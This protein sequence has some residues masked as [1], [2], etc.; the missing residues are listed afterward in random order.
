MLNNRPIFR[1]HK[2]PVARHKGR[3]PVILDFSEESTSPHFIEEMVAQTT[4]TIDGV[5]L[6]PQGLADLHVLDNKEIWVRAGR[7]PACF[8]THP[9]SKPAVP[10]PILDPDFL[11]RCDVSVMIGDLVLG[12]SASDE[13]DTIQNLAWLCSLSQEIGLPLAID[14][15]VFNP[16]EDQGSYLEIVELGLNLAIELGGNLVIIPA[17]A[18]LAADNHFEQIAALPVLVKQPTRH[19]TLENWPPQAWVSCLEKLDGV[20]FTGL[21]DRDQNNQ[22]PHIL[23]VWANSMQFQPVGG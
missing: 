1:E 20:I 6:S 13:A 19:L 21:Q 23:D 2:L 17:G 18:Y 11:S 12:G 4:A 9:L 3:L 5:I 15:H 8:P 14:L 7:A 22:T 10:S 16:W